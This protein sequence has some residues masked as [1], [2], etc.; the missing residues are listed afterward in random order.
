MK[1]WFLVLYFFPLIT[2]GKVDI[3]VTPQT[4]TEIDTLSLALRVT[5]PKGLK[6]PDI[7]QLTEHFHILNSQTSSQHQSMNG[8]VE[9]WVDYKYTLRPKKTGTIIIEPFKFGNS[10]SDSLEIVVK[11]LS[12][13]AKRQIEESIF[14]KTELTTSPIYVHGQTTYIRKLFFAPGVQL[15]SD[16]PEPPTIKDAVVT[17]LENPKPTQQTIKGISYGVIEQR[18]LIFPEKS[19]VIPIP[20]AFIT[21]SVRLNQAGVYRRTSIRISAPSISLDVLPIPKT[22]P[23]NK[24]WLPAT[25]LSIKDKW[26]PNELNLATGTQ[27][28]RELTITAV[29][30]SASAIS[31]LELKNGQQ[32]FKIYPKKPL[33]ENVIKQGGISGRRIETYTMIP[34]KPQELSIEPIEVTWWNIN[35]N[36]TNITKVPGRTLSIIGQSEESE[37]PSKKETLPAILPII[38][39]QEKSAPETSTFGELDITYI[40]TVTIIMVLI[41]LFVWSLTRWRLLHRRLSKNPLGILI[42]VVPLLNTS[43]PRTTKKR[44]LQHIMTSKKITKI[45]AIELL[46][47]DPKGYEILAKLNQRIYGKEVK[48]SD[49]ISLQEMWSLARRLSAKDKIQKPPPL[50]NL[51]T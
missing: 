8:K 43:S 31:P 13:S 39:S 21:S 26:F 25:Q 9:S 46:Q 37:S 50:P 48:E 40:I 17:P 19:G 34:L 23:K 11:P 15:Y 16:L 6:R 35:T 30:N 32:Y 33:L 3:K 36:K 20:E 2:F 44:L 27:I 29:G 14:F 10:Q 18:Y 51:Y 4:L 12:A 47:R 1:H 5:G 45:Q 22:Y 28:L 41:Y 38:N 49:I 42:R 24:P 7:K